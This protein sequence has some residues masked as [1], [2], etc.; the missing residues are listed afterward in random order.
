MKEA[1]KFFIR[2]DSENEDE[3]ANLALELI[4]QATVD[5][6][7]IDILKKLLRLWPDRPT[8][9]ELNRA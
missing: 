2:K 7:A 6:E 9:H 5:E 8:Y 1:H 3:V 4:Y